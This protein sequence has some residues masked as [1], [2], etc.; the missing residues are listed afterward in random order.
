[1]VS[2][3]R[4]EDKAIAGNLKISTLVV[5]L[6]KENL[7]T[8]IL[9]E[10]RKASTLWL[11]R[12]VLIYGFTYIDSI[13]GEFNILTPKLLTFFNILMFLQ[14]HR[15]CLNLSFRKHKSSINYAVKLRFNPIYDTKMSYEC[16]DIFMTKQ[17]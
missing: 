4:R 16:L 5:H 7:A 1:M 12:Y 10:K 8:Y 6:A 14:F 15:S 2:N 13:R 11:L 17:G 3:I 9:L